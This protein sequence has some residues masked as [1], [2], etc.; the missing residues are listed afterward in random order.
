MGTAGWFLACFFPTGGD[1]V[2]PPYP[3]DRDEVHR[4]LAPS[5]SIER[6]LEP[7]ASPKPRRGL[8]WMVYALRRCG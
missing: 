6:A 5:F 8:E 7:A 3:V 2:G 4:L 1:W